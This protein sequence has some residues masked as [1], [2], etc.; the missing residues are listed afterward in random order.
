[1]TIDESMMRP[2]LQ[3]IFASHFAHYAAQRKLPLRAHRAASAIVHCRTPALGGHIQ[4]CPEGH[5]ARMHY[6]ACRH[7]SCPRCSA[8]P[9]AR[10][11][12]TQ[13]A[14]LLA[15]EH[16]HVVFTLPH[17]LMALWAHNRPWFNATLFQCARD[18]LIELCADARFLGATPGI[19]MALHTWGRTLNPHPHVH[20]LVSGGGLTRA[21]DWKA[22]HNGYL[23]P[24]RVVKSLYRGKMLAAIG[25]ALEED[26]LRLPAQSTK[27]HWARCVR[28]L[29][30]KNWNVHLA[31]RYP[32][33]R[34]VLR[35]LARYVKG[36]PIP[37]QR[38]Q[39][40]NAQQVVFRYTDHHDGAQK[41]MRLATGEFIARVLWHAPE[42]GQHTVRHYGLYANS[43][44]TRLER[45]REH[46]GQLPVP[47]V[48]SANWQA[49]LERLGAV[50][51]TRCP[52][53][54][55]PLI[56]GA[57]LARA[58]ALKQI[59]LSN[60]VPSRFAQLGVE[61]DTPTLPSIHG[62]GPPGTRG[63]FFFRR[64]RAA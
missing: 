36:G 58:Q 56:R 18:T 44:H 11:A 1:L 19:I 31:Q 15:C 64:R 25:E 29:H 30:R 54:K 13:A 12:Q 48:P 34:G 51:K 27:A 46:L 47:A 35:Y 37:E 4:R 63:S 14:R 17:E 28:R 24:V 16:Y 43:A 9:R 60:A 5:V 42:T 22:V 50:D 33:G 45:A 53:C 23:L 6:N 7:R 62:I 55:L 20:C 32:H 26:R 38:L 41:R 21:G 39:S 52:R 8:L 61:A 10:W 3:A 40:A 59:S 49:E 2:T 57:N